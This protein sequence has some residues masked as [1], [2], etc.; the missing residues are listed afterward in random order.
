SFEVTRLGYSRVEKIPIQGIDNN[1]QNEIFSRP[2]LVWIGA[3]GCSLVE[4][5]VSKQRCRSLSVGQQQIPPEG[6]PLSSLYRPAPTRSKLIND[7]GSISQNWIRPWFR[8]H[9]TS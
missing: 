5:Q 4:R 3:A 6:S 1:L 7:E 2:A 9:I 8:V